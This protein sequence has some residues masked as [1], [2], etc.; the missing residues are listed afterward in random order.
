MIITMIA[1]LFSLSPF[2]VFSSASFVID[3]LPSP[4][5]LKAA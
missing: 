3:Q 2:F 1:N 5:A 4:S